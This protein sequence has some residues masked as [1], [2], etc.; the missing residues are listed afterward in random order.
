MRQEADNMIRFSSEMPQV[1]DIVNTPSRQGI[2]LRVV[3]QGHPRRIML[4]DN[5]DVH[6][7]PCPGSPAYGPDGTDSGL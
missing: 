2:E 3:F 5:D 4:W 6:L 1:F 7:G